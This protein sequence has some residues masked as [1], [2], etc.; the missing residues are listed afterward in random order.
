[1]NDNVKYCREVLGKSMAACDI[2]EDD[3]LMVYSFRSDGKY[4][5]KYIKGEVMQIAEAVCEDGTD[6]LFCN[7]DDY[8][9]FNT[10]GR[11]LDAHIGLSDDFITELYKGISR[12]MLSHMK[13]S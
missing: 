1:M 9:L 13:Y 12:V 11:V 6:K 10:R 5:K 4:S 8:G 2:N 7:G 3:T